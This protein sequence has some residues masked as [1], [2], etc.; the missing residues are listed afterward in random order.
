M[1]RIRGSQVAVVGGSIAGCAAAI[2]LTRAGCAVTVCERSRGGLRDR[3]AG[4]TIAASLYD[5]LVDA[6]Y[7]DRGMRTRRRRALTWLCRA[8]DDPDGRV[9]GRQP[10]PSI[11]ASWTLVWRGLRDQVAEMA[12]RE[13]STVT[14][15][16]PVDDG[17]ELSVDGHPAGTFAAVV[18]ADGLRSRVRPVIAPEATV[19]YG[20]YGLWRGDYPVERLPAAQRPTL[21]EEFVAV[22][23][24]GG[25]V[26]F[27]QIPDAAPGRLRQNWALYG[28][29]PDWI[30]L[31]G[32]STIPRRQVTP[33]AVAY[34]HDLAARELP[35]A[36]ADAVRRTDQQELSISPM[37]DTTV[38][39]YAANRMLLIGDAGAIARPH[40]GAGAVKAIQD[41]CALERACREHEQWDEALD[42]YDAARR[43]AGNALTRLGQHLGRMRVQESPD[44]AA[45]TDTDFQTWLHANTHGWQSAYDPA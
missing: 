28:D 32:A 41:A 16:R 11:M 27:Y 39:R 44:W 22:G 4:I 25:H 42:A 40:T 1:R 24:H 15:I 19:D 20:G 13:G 26:V 18:G 10:Y 37:Y 33:S 7:L 6:G 9:I 34:L 8:G 29:V 5:E 45:M 12:Y 38:S 31:D 14:D 43:D 36:W 2:A 23:F 30:Y 35:P 3:G 17:V 21:I